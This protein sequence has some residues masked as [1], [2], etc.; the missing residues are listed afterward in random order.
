MEGTEKSCQLA[1]SQIYFPSVSTEKGFY[2]TDQFA[3][4]ENL[5]SGR[6]GKKLA[7]G[8]KKEPKEDHG[9]TRIRD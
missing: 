3:S 2:G 8:K 1:I 6:N 9:F 4:T 5:S 7:V